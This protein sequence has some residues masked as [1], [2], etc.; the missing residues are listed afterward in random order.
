MN[1]ILF[2]K[3]IILFAA[4]IFLLTACEDTVEV[5][6]NTEDLDLITVEA[7]INTKANDNIFVKL[8]KSIQVDKEGINPPINNA[9]VEISDDQS[10]A[11]SVLLQEQG[12]TGV[13]T[14]PEEESYEASPGR[15]YTLNITTPDG[16][17]ITASEYLQEVE[18]LDSV[19]INLSNQG[20]Y[21][22]LGIHI[23]SQETPGEGHYY[24]WDIYIN[25]DFLNDSE[26]LAYA[27]DE[28]VDGN[29]IYDLTIL[30]DWEEEDKILHLG[31]TVLVEQL[32]ISEEAYDFY[33]GLED[34]AWAGGPFSVP[35]ANIPSN[36]KSNN[37]KR[38]LG[39]FSARDISVGNTVVIDESN[40]TPLVSSINF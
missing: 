6:L 39:L 14:L 37:G 36:L 17:I 23:N 22:Y 13:Y 29:Y 19:K 9:L 32:S 30:L 33:R 24:K 38:I 8:E 34:Q 16:T 15:T 27:S 5:D 4:A 3:I 20:D 10:P 26:D 40:Y 12:N 25:G 28:L 31:D 11:A 2:N 7:Y 1:N 35:P 18:N 21:E